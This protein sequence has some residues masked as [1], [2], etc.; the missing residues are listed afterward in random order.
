M[1]VRVR[2][3]SVVV[4]SA[5][6]DGHPD[7]VSRSRAVASSSDGTLTAQ[8]FAGEA[9]RRAW[10]T[11]L[12][13]RG[14]AASDFL[15]FDAACEPVGPGTWV[16]TE[17][18]PDGDVEGWIRGGGRGQLAPHVPASRAPFERHEIL[19]RSE[20]GLHFVRE[21]K[22]GVLRQLTE[23]EL[24]DFSDPQPCAECGE[25]FGCEHFNCAGERL[26]GDADIAATVPNEWLAFARDSGVS[27]E[28]LGRL[29][30]IECH[31]GEYR[32]ATDAPS[33]MRTLEL[34]L[35]LNEGR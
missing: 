29:A 10:L 33:D 17:R 11:R 22:S 12:R 20:S 7:L 3:G 16:A 32:R 25:Q 26:L 6:L 2:S 34:V 4:R 14:L 8:S 1:S 5:A 35:L 19:S 31:E 13:E 21:R 18:L 9:D 23:S 27:R 28:D 24:L 15:E 30:S